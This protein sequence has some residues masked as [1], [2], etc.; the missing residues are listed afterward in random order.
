MPVGAAFCSN[1]GTQIGDSSFSSDHGDPEKPL[2]DTNNPGS[3]HFDPLAVAETI[4]PTALVTSMDS[5]SPRPP[6]RP[7]DGPFQTGQQVGPRYTILK[8]L[9]T[10]GMGAVYQAFDHELGVAVAIKVIRPSAQSDATA[11]KE[12]EQRFKRELVLARQVTHKYVVRIHDLGEIDGIKYLTMPYIEGETLAM[13]VRR[14]GTL[15]LPRAIQIATQIAQGL[16]AAHEKG[17]IHR[18]L[19]PENI[20]IERSSES[21]VP[22]GGG[23]ALIMD[24]GIARSVEHG[25]TQTAAGAVI[26]TLEYMAPE[27]AQGGQVDQRADQYAFGLIFYDMLVGRQR[28]NRGDNPMTELL[29]R[30]QSTPTAPSTINPE[31]PE[32]VNQIVMR[33]LQPNPEARYATTA[34]LV[35]ALE[36]LTPDGH[37]RTDLHEVVTLPAPPRPRWQLAIAGLLIVALAGTAGWLAL[38]RNVAPPVAVEREPISVL[39]ADFTNSTGDPV[40]DGVVEQALGLGIE[41]ASF[42][43]AYPR[44]DALRAAAVI[45]KSTKLDEATALLVARREG[46]GL[47]LAG[48]IEARGGSYHITTRAIR[49]GVNDATVLYSLEA[50]AAGKAQ[51]LET[52]GSLAGQVRTQL[53]DTAVPKEGP[54]ANETFT[55]ANLEA[56]RAYAQAQALQAAGKGEDAIAQY[57]EALKLDPDLGRAYAGLG[58]AMANLGRRQEAEE[59]YNQAIQRIDRMTPREKLRTRSGYFLLVRK[60]DQ[61]REQLEELVKQFPADSVGLSNLAVTHGQQRDMERALEVGRK[62]SAIYPMNVLRKNNVAMFAMYSSKFEEA[63]KQAAAVLEMNKEYPKAFFA[64]GMS[65]LALGRPADATATFTRAAGLSGAARDFAMAGLADQAM[66]EGRLADAAGILDKA[67]ASPGAPTAVPRYKV[68]LAEVRARQGRSADAVRMTDEIL[69]GTPDLPVHLAVRFFAGRVAIESGKPADA[70][71]ASLGQALDSESR[72]HGKLLEG[73]AML[74]RGNAREALARFREAQQLSDSWLGRFGLGRAYLEL[75]EFVEAQGEFER[76]LKRQGEATNLLLD[77]IATYRFVATIHYYLGRAQEGV[78]SPA[79]AASYKTFLD[80]KQRG[81]E[82]GGLV[83]DARRRLAAQ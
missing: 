12:L 81:D 5:P 31:I 82:T 69:K 61:A 75:G 10:G 30:L 32:P 67:I 14:A 65:Q 54:A 37:L 60:A 76:C 17:V 3:G 15:P 62:A 72:L 41:G 43:T 55:A 40:F 48:G 36:R 6:V 59:Y 66:Y 2:T 34:D 42:I 20:M 7:E 27:Q 22:G 64:M 23:D 13:I 79:A 80:I 68:M 73:E 21:P 77:D 53:G 57:K 26:G 1:C 51:V 56:A 74:A 49:A 29:T 33:C 45:N 35:H 63:E 11:A 28:L 8:L 18:D 16:C 78:K 50:E 83:A 24:F 44:R 47:I 4:N 70:L 25:A 46:V 58:A 52:V 9:G 39:I 38:N 19:K 71:I